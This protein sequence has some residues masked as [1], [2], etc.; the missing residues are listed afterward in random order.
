MTCILK[1][2]IIKLQKY[3][4]VVLMLYV[5]VQC[6]IVREGEAT[7][8]IKDVDGKFCLDPETAVDVVQHILKSSQ[9]T[10]YDVFVLCEH[11]GVM[12]SM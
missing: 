11:V 10:S 1:A 9:M 8:V 4:T 7:M 3:K 6:T 2:K 5:Q 12:L